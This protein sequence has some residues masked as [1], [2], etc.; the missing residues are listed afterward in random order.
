M[1]M[2]SMFVFLFVV[3]W[4][5]IGGWSFVYWWT[6]SH[7]FTTDELPMMC[8]VS[9]IGPF[10]FFFGWF[11]HGKPLFRRKIIK[12]KKYDPN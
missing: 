3:F 12:L 7:D 11:I 8:F 1:I 6:T 4:L 2:I 9:I 10:A 5:I